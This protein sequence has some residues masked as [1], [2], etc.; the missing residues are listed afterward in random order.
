MDEDDAENLLLFPLPRDSNHHVRSGARSPALRRGR[1]ASAEARLGPPWR[2]VVPGYSPGPGWMRMLQQTCCSSHSPGTLTITRAGKAHTGTDLYRDAGGGSAGRARAAARRLG[3][4]FTVLVEMCSVSRKGTPACFPL[5]PTVSRRRRAVTLMYRTAPASQAGLTHRPS[6]RT[7][8]ALPA[9]PHG[10][11]SASHVQPS[12]PSPRLG[13]PGPPGKHRC[14]ARSAKGEHTNASLTLSRLELCRS[15]G[16]SSGRAVSGQSRSQPEASKDRCE[17]KSVPSRWFFSV[18]RSAGDRK[19]GLYP[20]SLRG[21]TPGDGS[22]EHG[23]LGAERQQPGI[24][25][26]TRRASTLGIR[27]LYF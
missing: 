2:L 8:T 6:R 17:S 25:L 23:K 10:P 16:A 13:S 22:T 9:E 24:E 15:R 4:G 26:S 27:T 3:V 14:A 7:D 12:P 11:P 21:L 5:D 20:T 19:D 18:G 1:A